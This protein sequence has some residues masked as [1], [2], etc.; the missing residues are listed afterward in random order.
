M[1]FENYP[2]RPLDYDPFLSFDLLNETG[3][4]Y[5]RSLYVFYLGAFF[6][7]SNYVAVLKRFRSPKSRACR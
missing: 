1:L 7:R 6:H 3:Q 5:K 2:I 4:M